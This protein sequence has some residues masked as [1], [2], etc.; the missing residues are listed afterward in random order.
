VLAM[1]ERM[2]TDVINKGTRITGWR[3]FSDPIYQNNQA[4]LYIG[5]QLL[6]GELKVSPTGDGTFHTVYP[7][8]QPP[9]YDLNL[10]T[11]T[12]LPNLVGNPSYSLM[13]PPLFYYMWADAKFVPGAAES[14]DLR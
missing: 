3:D 12:S 7:Y 11:E 6:N 8:P 10:Y 13:Y 1:F 14:Y 2:A 9:N 5:I 4:D